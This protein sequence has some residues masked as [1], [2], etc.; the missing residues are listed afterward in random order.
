VHRLPD[1]QSKFSAW[2]AKW[3]G[4]VDRIVIGKTSTGFPLEGL[5]VTDESVAFDAA[6]TATGQKLRVYLDGG[7]HGNEYLGVELVMYY[8]QDLLE[9]SGDETVAAFLKETEVY[10]VPIINVDG[11]LLD[12]RKNG[13]L[14]DMNRNYDFQ[15]GGPGS[16]GDILS[17]TYRG[18]SPASELEVQAN[19]AFGAEIRPDVWITMHTGIA[20]FYWPWGWTHDK[21]PDWEFFESI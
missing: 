7:H 9:S 20:E 2:D 16:S 18:P 13:R 11:N 21:A 8:L 1:V 17:F 4:L 10:A 5:R 3:S 19:Q 12:T 14:V 6:S 15:W